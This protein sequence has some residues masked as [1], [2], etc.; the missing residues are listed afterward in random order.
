MITFDSIPVYNYSYLAN[1]LNPTSGAIFTDVV[2][3]V[4]VWVCSDWITFFKE[5]KNKYGEQKAKE[6][7]SWWWT[8]GLSVSAGGQGDPR[9]GSGLVYDS[10]PLDCRSFDSDF[11]SF[12]TKHNLSDTVYKGLGV[13]TKPIGFA[14]DIVKDVT[15][16]VTSTSKII[17]YGVPAL[18]VVGMGLLVWYGV[19]KIKST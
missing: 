11:R 15:S 12:I 14:S 7:W 19:S 6:Y 1:A 5:L 2:R 18:L 8:L 10:V 16:A 3:K 4:P 13:I 17:K 9:A